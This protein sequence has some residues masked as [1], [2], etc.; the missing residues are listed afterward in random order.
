[1]DY[2]SKARELAENLIGSCRNLDEEEQ[3]L[4]DVMEFC[5][6][7]DA[8]AFICDV[9][10]WWCGEDE[11]HDGTTCHECADGDDDD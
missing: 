3:A 2:A 1:M 9:C 7:F 4:F 6:A 8:L 11:R 10:E 5:N